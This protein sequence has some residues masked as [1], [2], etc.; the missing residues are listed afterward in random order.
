MLVKFRKANISEYILKIRSCA[1]RMTLK[2]LL[3]NWA[4]SETGHKQVFW[5]KFHTLADLMPLR[6]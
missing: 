1:R 5:L 2:A 3:V 4:F 6:Q